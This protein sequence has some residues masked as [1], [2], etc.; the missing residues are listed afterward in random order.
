MDDHERNIHLLLTR[1]SSCERQLDGFTFIA[2]AKD[3]K[4]YEKAISTL[5]DYR[6]LGEDLDRAIIEAKVLIER[7]KATAFY[8]NVLIK[9][10]CCVAIG[11]CLYGSG[12]RN[13][14]NALLIL[15]GCL[16]MISAWM[17]QF[18]VNEYVLSQ[19]S[20]NPKIG[21]LAAIRAKLSALFL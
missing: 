15:F 2:G 21:L 20:L 14:L 11:I 8:P 5:G 9:G 7:S 19:Q 12:G 6:E 3:L 1:A 13:P 17:P 18:A 16:S 10:A 4:E